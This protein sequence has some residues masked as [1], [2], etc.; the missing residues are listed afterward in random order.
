MADLWFDT[1]VDAILRRALDAVSLRQ[2]VIAN[3]I[4]N[5]DTPG[6]VAQ[7][8]DFEGALQAALSRGSQPHLAL[9]V[10]NPGHLGV[11]TSQALPQPR[12]VASTGGA[13]RNDGNTVDVDAEMA[14]L[15]KNTIAYNALATQ[16]ASR[17]AM[18]RTVIEEGR[19]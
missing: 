5:A 11:G 19:S 9:V 4:A 12:V 6:Y 14:A 1:G 2:S 16:L 18:W 8:V 15:A 17:L 13:M 3:N 7:T 10:T